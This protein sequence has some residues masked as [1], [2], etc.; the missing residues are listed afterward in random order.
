MVENPIIAG[1]AG[2]ICGIF[3]GLGIGGGSLLM[4]W[5][6]GIA[7]VK[8]IT[9]QGINL[10]Y[11]FPTVLGAFVFHKREQTIVWHA[12]IPAAVAGCLTAALA[13]FIASGMDVELLRKLFGA[14]LIFVGLTELFR[15][16]AQ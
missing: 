3:S 1:F 16:K 2:L 14:F 6:T 11:F 7:S 12:V 9:A 5:L 13:A 15:K 8:Q 4:V 10:L